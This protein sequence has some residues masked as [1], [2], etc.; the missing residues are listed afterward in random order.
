MWLS[1]L[2][3]NNLGHK[4]VG[5]LFFSSHSWQ[6]HS[7]KAMRHSISTILIAVFP[8]A[9][10]SWVVSFMFSAIFYP[11]GFMARII[12]SFSFTFSSSFTFSFPFL[13]S[14]LYLCWLLCFLLVT[15]NGNGSKWLRSKFHPVHHPTS[16]YP[17]EDTSGK[18]K[19][20][21]INSTLNI[22]SQSPK[23]KNKGYLAERYCLC[24]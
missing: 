2:L 9:L 5:N 22:P 23:H 10:I 13:K 8:V 17:V 4:A 15:K 12:S 1:W 3:G 18:R 7:T 14:I 11:I 24:V 6:Y 20:T 19:N 16:E 21:W